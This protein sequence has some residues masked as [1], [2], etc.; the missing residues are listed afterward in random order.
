MR[1]AAVALSGNS[2]NDAGVALIHEH[3]VSS[4]SQRTKQRVVANSMPTWTSLQLDSPDAKTSVATMASRSQQA[5]ISDGSLVGTAAVPEVAP[6]T[7]PTT[8]LDLALNRLKRTK[9]CTYYA[10]IELAKRVVLSPSSLWV[11]RMAYFLEFSTARL[12]V[13]STYFKSK[14]LAR[15]SA[16]V[17]PSKLRTMALTT[18]SFAIISEPESSVANYGASSIFAGYKCI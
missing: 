2:S 15:V 7:E 11:I 4:T 14:L 13:L 17:I 18:G 6:A 9:T 5:Q 8:E 12:T 16:D 1:I 3:Q 10:A